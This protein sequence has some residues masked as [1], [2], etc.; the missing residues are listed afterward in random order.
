MLCRSRHSITP[1]A[2]PGLRNQRRSLD[3]RIHL[4]RRQSRQ[5]HLALLHP[6]VVAA[7]TVWPTPWLPRAGCRQTSSLADAGAR[8]RARTV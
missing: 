3:H 8:P 5:L 2:V 4:H 1:Q 7:S 6:R